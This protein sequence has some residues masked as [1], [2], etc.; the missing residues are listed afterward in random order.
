[1]VDEYEAEASNSM[2]SVAATIVAQPVEQQPTG[3]LNQPTEQHT[4]ESQMPQK[5]VENEQKIDPSNESDKAKQEN[6]PFMLN[7]MADIVGNLGQIKDA[8]G[9]TLLGNRSRQKM[10]GKM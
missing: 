4:A 9:K 5:P 6:K 10:T 7:K 8:I 3:T 1:M 2:D